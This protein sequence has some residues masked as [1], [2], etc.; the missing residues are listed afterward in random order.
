MTAEEQIE[1]ILMEAS[2][3]GLRVEIL[4][5]AQKYL[6]EGYDRVTSYEMAYQEW[7]K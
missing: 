4:E 2:A 1:E 7:I 6:N 5:T 3:L